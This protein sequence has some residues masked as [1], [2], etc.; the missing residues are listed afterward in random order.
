MKRTTD[1]ISLCV[2]VRKEDHFRDT[3]MFADD[4]ADTKKTHQASVWFDGEQI[5]DIYSRGGLVGRNETPE[6]CGISRHRAIENATG[7][8]IVIIDAHM[9]LPKGW[10]TAVL[11]H[12]AGPK[13]AKDV[14]C[15]RMVAMDEWG[16][17]GKLY[18]G[19]ELVLKSSC[20]GVGFTALQGVWKDQPL[21]EIGCCMGAFYAFRK[22]WYAQMG[23]P[24]GVLQG[25]GCDEEMLSLGSWL[26]GGR[27]VLADI[28]AA[29]LMQKPGRY[30]PEPG[31]H[32]RVWRNRFRLINLLPMSDFMR[33]DLNE[34]L[35]LNP[36]AMSSAFVE[37][38]G[39]DAQR[40]EVMALKSLWAAHAPAWEAY[41]E[42]FVN[43]VTRIAQAG[44]NEAL[45]PEQVK[46][47][48][49]YDTAAPRLQ[50]IPQGDP[51]PIRAT[52]CQVLDL[53]IC[54]RC[55]AVDDLRV[56]RTRQQKAGC[57]SREGMCRKCKTPF[58][59]TDIGAERKITWEK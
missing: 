33:R 37:A 56:T 3:L 8:I 26:M 21:G 24:L 27:V 57:V 36:I 41:R 2:A 43:H 32:G 58:K 55:K 54:P 17:M 29:H 15:G 35:C 20:H 59:A 23:Q 51:R 11:D 19:A 16:K 6:G 25:W 9:I 46:A 12:F 47:V 50:D 28:R 38:V 53:P 52:N 30:A 45:K 18:S 10:D 34:W 13:N 4:G 39:H 42:R 49:V 7:D 5:T 14:L 44:A 40:P 31:Q 1:T 22:G 48:H